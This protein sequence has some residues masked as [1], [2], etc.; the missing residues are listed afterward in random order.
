MRTSSPSRSTHPASSAVE[1]PEALRAHQAV[2]EAAYSEKP[3]VYRQVLDYFNA[4]LERLLNQPEPTICDVGANVGFFSLEVIRRT[5]GRVKLHAFEPIPDTFAQLQRNLGALDLKDVHVHN[6]GLGEAEMKVRFSCNPWVSTVSSRYDMYG[7]DDDRM[8]LDI[9]YHP[10]LAAKFHVPIPAF[11]RWL[12]RPA[13]RLLI[14]SLGWLMRHTLAR[15]QQVECQLKTLSQIMREQNLQQIDLLKIDVE[16]AELD[17]LKGI[18]AADWAKIQAV[19]MEVHD[20]DSR[21]RFIRE[22]LQ[23][24][25]FRRIEEDRV[26][27]NQFVIGL[28]AFR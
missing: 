6:C 17:V 11:L 20:I 15:P 24:Q 22:L 25:G 3:V 10:E 28:S 18:D 26:V 14:R 9:I 8:G 5:A 16:K 12:P 13:T 19:V 2:F 1:L 4:D 21:V 27:A 7:A 23:R